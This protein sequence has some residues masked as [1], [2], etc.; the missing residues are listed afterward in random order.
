MRRGLYDGAWFMTFVPNI[1]RGASGARPRPA[2]QWARLLLA[3][4]L[5][6][7][8]GCGQSED[9]SPGPTSLPSDTDAGTGAGGSENDVPD[10][11]LDC[12]E[13]TGR[14]DRC[15]CNAS[16]QCEF[17]CVA[18]LPGILSPSDDEPCRA[19]ELGSCTE[20]ATPPGC[21]CVLGHRESESDPEQTQ[22][23]CWDGFY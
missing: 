13:D 11:P 10:P 17:E 12:E 3:G 20:I 9:V 23:V 2:F 8:S 4:S 7:A 22:I 14:P 19:V 5:L 15:P 1:S 6:G 21:H 16:A 18:E